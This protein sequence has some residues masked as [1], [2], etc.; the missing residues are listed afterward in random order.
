L[1]YAFIIAA[2]PARRRAAGQG[3][4]SAGGAR[5]RGLTSGSSFR[6]AYRADTAAARRR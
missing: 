3:E 6:S 2:Y 1:D 5:V 4:T